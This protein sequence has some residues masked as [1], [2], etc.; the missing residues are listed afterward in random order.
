MA[1]TLSLEVPY[2]VSSPETHNIKVVT[3]EVD[4]GEM[5]NIQ[6]MNIGNLLHDTMALIKVSDDVDPVLSDLKLQLVDEPSLFSEIKNM[7]SLIVEHSG[8]HHL[9][10]ASERIYNERDIITPDCILRPDRV[11]VHPNN[12]VTI[13][14]YKTGVEKESYEFQINSY[15]AALQDMGYTVKEKLLVYCHHDAILINKT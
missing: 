2:I 9:F 12:T 1:D 15:T 5:D 8:L 3:S 11:N 4:R 13:V 10:Q 14:D 6:A 7:I